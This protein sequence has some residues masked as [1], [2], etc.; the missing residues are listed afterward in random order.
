MDSVTDFLIFSFLLVLSKGDEEVGWDDKWSYH[1]LNGPDY[2]GLMHSEWTRCHNGKFQSPINLVSKRLIYDAHLGLFEFDYEDLG[3]LGGNYTNT[4]RAP[5]FTPRPEDAATFTVRG[6]PLHYEYQIHDLWI[7]FGENENE[8][9]DHLIEGN[10]FQGE[11][12]ITFWNKGLYNSY[13]EAEVSPR[14]LAAIAIFLQK[15][16]KT[17]DMKSELAKLTRANVLSSIVYKGSS[18]GI[19]DLNVLKL[20]PDT[21]EYI[22]YEGSLTSPPCYETVTWIVLNKPIHISEMELSNIR[23]L[24]R[25]EEMTTVEVGDTQQAVQTRLLESNFR[26]VKP[27]GNRAIR[28]NIGHVQNLDEKCYQNRIEHTYKASVL[29]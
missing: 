2:W 9:S 14:G 16:N 28:T 12:Q 15:G 6:G 3:E 17:S 18:V 13:K 11:I 4:G 21:T 7:H 10:A 22:T 29:T 24:R 5:V 20:M 25:E 19:P 26:G 27:R 23:E 8:G 1:G